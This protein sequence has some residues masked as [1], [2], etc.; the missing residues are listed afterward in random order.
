MVRIL[1][2]YIPTRRPRRAGPFRTLAPPLPHTHK[3]R[4]SPACL[5][6]RDNYTLAWAARGFVEIWLKS[7]HPKETC[8][9]HLN[10]FALIFLFAC[11]YSN[12]CLCGGACVCVCWY[13]RAL[14]AS[15]TGRA[16]VRTLRTNFDKSSSN[17]W[18]N[19]WWRA[20]PRMRM[21]RELLW[22]GCVRTQAVG[23]V[24]DMSV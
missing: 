20:G 2:L 16:F 7:L 23:L 4:P 5:F 12:V 10:V 9:Q 22:L 11:E 6:K 13:T 8:T 1:P 3:S 15:S 21:Q 18:T 14:F 24:F 19:F 17:L